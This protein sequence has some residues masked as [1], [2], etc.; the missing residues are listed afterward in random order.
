MNKFGT[1]QMQRMIDELRVASAS[2]SA[3]HLSKLLTDAADSLE[4][5]QNYHGAVESAL[6]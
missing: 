6:V 5:A 3:P 1:D 4:A 2:D